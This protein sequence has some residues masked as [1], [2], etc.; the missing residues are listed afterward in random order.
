M[1]QLPPGGPLASILS[2]PSAILPSAMIT[3]SPMN[4]CLVMTL[5]C[6]RI[7]SVSPFL[8]RSSLNLHSGILRPLSAWHH[9]TQTI[10]FST[11]CSNSPS[12]F[13][14]API[15]H[16]MFIPPLNFCSYYSHHLVCLL[17]AYTFLKVVYVSPFLRSLLQ[18]LQLMFISL[19][20]IY[21]VC[22]IF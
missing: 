1:Y 9:L 22:L 8:M 6:S 3:L 18:T 17:S 16:A 20:I 7:Y 5:D 10:L 4:P 21:Y 13:T 12:P 2:P 14:P 15:K 19:P 11:L